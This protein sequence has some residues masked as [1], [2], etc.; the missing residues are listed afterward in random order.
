MTLTFKFGDR[1]RFKIGRNPQTKDR[2]IGAIARSKLRATIGIDSRIIKTDLL[3]R[4][5]IFHSQE[6][7][8]KDSLISAPYPIA[9]G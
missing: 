4:D 2:L 1:S 5:K 7:N 9:T 3:S 8:R 6:Q